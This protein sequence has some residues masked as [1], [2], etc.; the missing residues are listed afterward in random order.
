MIRHA[1]IE[2]G[3]LI[4]SNPAPATRAQDVAAAAAA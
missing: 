1:P 2:D 4:F 3:A